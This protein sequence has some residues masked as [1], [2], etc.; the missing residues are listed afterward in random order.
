MNKESQKLSSSAFKEYLE[1]HHGQLVAN[2][3]FKGYNFFECDNEVLVIENPFEKNAILYYNKTKYYSD[4]DKLVKYQKFNPLAGKQLYVK[5]IEA[6]KIE[7][8]DSLFSALQIQKP[9]SLTD[10]NLSVFDK[11]IK[12]YG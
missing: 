11:K 5:D 2:P 3:Y 1:L 9:V 12:E 7:L 4:M 10:V 8:L 6:Y